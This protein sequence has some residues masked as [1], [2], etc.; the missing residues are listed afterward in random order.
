MFFE[1]RIIKKLKFRNS[2]FS[3]GDDILLI[4][5]PSRYG[6][7]KIVTIAKIPSL[8]FPILLVA[9]YYPKNDPLIQDLQLT[10][11]SKNELILSDFQDWQYVESIKGKMK[12]FTE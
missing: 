9:W 8:Q 5:G 11:L 6:Q 2:I 3:T 12:V 7:A 10:H 1:L 4:Q